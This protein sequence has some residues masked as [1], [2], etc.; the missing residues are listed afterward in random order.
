MVIQKSIG[1][2]IIEKLKEIIQKIEVE[3]ERKE[4]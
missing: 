1:E 3:D 2:E 4:E